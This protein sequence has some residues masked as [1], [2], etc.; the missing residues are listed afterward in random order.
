MFQ[1]KYFERNDIEFIRTI[2]S[3]FG[4]LIAHSVNVARWRG[5]M[6][7]IAPLCY[8]CH[9]CYMKGSRRCSYPPTTS[10]R[11]IFFGMDELVLD[12]RPATIGKDVCERMRAY[13]APRNE[14]LMCVIWRL[15]MMQCPGFNIALFERAAID[16]GSSA[17]RWNHSK[18]CTCTGYFCN[19]IIYLFIKLHCNREHV[20]H[21]SW[22]PIRMTKT[23]DVTC[24]VDFGLGNIS[25]N[26]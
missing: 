9:Y 4:H 2:H 26:N 24:F 14:P 17:K 13:F 23:H 7:K 10:V 15:N 1:E 18:Q 3:F 6:S 8:Y 19:C 12:G 22:K 5:W 11:P 20:Y 21:V 25:S 16:V